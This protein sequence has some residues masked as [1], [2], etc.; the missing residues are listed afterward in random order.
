MAK[1]ICIL[2]DDESIRE[3]IELILGE[4]AYEVLAFASV[5]EF[6]HSDRKKNTDLFLLDVMLPDGN[7]IDICGMLKSAKETCNIPVLMMSA[8]VSPSQIQ[9]CCQAD[10]FV[11]KPFDISDLL[12]KVSQTLHN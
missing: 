11:A 4:E 10:G 8:N 7:G 6:I 1:R 3:V 12:G 5:G 2:E 9:N